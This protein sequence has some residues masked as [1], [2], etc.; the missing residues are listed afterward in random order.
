MVCCRS[1]GLKSV[2]ELNELRS[3]LIFKQL[4]DYDYSEAGLFREA[5][6]KGQSFEP[7]KMLKKYRLDT[8][9]KA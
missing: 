1:L 5:F 3:P 9:F 7:V 4:D 2:N 8:G 6:S